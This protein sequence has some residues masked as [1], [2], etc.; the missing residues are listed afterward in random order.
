M[1][2]VEATGCRSK[3]PNGLTETFSSEASTA[4]WIGEGSGSADDLSGRGLVAVV[5]KAKRK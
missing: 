4:Q 5:A 1:K 3:G 2:S